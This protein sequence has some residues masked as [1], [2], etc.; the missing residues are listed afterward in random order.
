M[1]YKFLFILFTL[2]LSSCSHFKTEPAFQPLERGPSAATQDCQQLVKNLFMT[3]DYESGFQ[4]ALVDKKLLKFSNKFVT[5]QHPNLDWINRARISLNKSIK[6]WNSNK[7]PAFYIFNDE[8]VVTVAKQYFET[9]NSIVSP[10]MAV[11]PEATKNYETVMSWMK[12]FESYQKDIDQLLEERISLQYNLS[13]LKKLKL[14]D[15]ETDI[16]ITVKRNG[17]LVDEVLTLRKSDKDKAFQIKRLKSEIKELDGTIFKNGKIKDRTI[18]QAMLLDMLTIIQREF[19]AGMKNTEIP[20]PELAKELKRINDLL[21][22][23]EFQP[24]TFGVY[25]VTNK[26]FTREIIALSKV[27]VAYKKFIEPKILKA[28]EIFDAYIENRPKDPK[29]IGILKRI[30]SKITNIS[31]KQAAIGTSLTTIG[32]V[33]YDRY[34]AFHDSRAEEVIVVLKNEDGLE[35]GHIE[36]LER[37]QKEDVQ[38]VN[39]HNEVI[40]VEIN[41]LTNP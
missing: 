27:D 15:E 23:S 3:E 35:T 26:V 41:E 14:K 7:Y 22:F 31:A 18:R 13:I 28:K 2:L 33:G 21:K 32:I 1:V 9:I 8:D 19:E 6:N 12:A 11:A 29:K 5:I 39:E 38:R 10:D 34:A 4:K 17:N 16:K 37:T 25:R 20:N 36:Q 24:T 30:Y 40:E